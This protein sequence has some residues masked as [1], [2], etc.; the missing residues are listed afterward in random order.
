MVLGSR[1]TDFEVLVRDCLLTVNSCTRSPRP[2]MYV[3]FESVQYKGHSLGFAFSM[4]DI[5]F[6]D[7]LTPEQKKLIYMRLGKGKIVSYRGM[8]K[9]F[10]GHRDLIRLRYKEA[11][12]ILE[13]VAVYDTYLA[14]Q[15]IEKA[16]ESEFF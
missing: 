12:K 1:L 2:P 5:F 14:A 15:V 4:L 11:I 9:R 16:R 3:D 13:S 6:T 7:R 8:V 10:G